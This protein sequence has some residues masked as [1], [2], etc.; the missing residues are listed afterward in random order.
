MKDAAEHVMTMSMDEELKIN[1]QFEAELVLRYF[2][3][4][5]TH[6]A[7]V[8]EF[9][10]R[11]TFITLE[12]PRLVFDFMIAFWMEA[13]K[14]PEKIFKLTVRRI[15]AL[16][17][18][19]LRN[20]KMDQLQ[21]A[22]EAGLEK[23]TKNTELLLEAPLVFLLLTHPIHGPNV[24]RAVLAVLHSIGNEEE[25]EASFDIDDF[26]T[27]EDKYFEADTEMMDEIE[28]LSWAT[29]NYAPDSMPEGMRPFLTSL[30]T[31]G[32]TCSHSGINLDCNKQLCGKS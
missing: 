20:Q 12:M 28:G 26:S 22:I 3:V 13:M 32:R 19:D 2:D 8:G 11:A 31:T 29:Y 23:V 5:L 6:H 1:L 21:A 7:F 9:G 16:S 24:L 27:E 18:E 14:D 4:T 15:K 30:S 17:D 10:R 25:G